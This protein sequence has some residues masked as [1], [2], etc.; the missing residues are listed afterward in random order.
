[1]ENLQYSKVTNWGGVIQDAIP[2]NIPLGMFSDALNFELTRQGGLHPRLGF[3]KYATTPTPDGRS[4]RQIFWADLDG[5][6][7]LLVSTDQHVYEFIRASDTWSLI[8]TMTSTSTKRMGFALLNANTA[9]IVIFGNGVD[10]LKQWDGTTVTNCVGAPVGRPVAFKNYIA[11]FDIVGYPGKVQFSINPGDPD[12]WIYGGQ[13]KYLEMRGK[14][15]SIFP[16]GGGLLVY[17]ETRTEFFVGDPDYAQG[18]TSLS[19]TIGCSSHETVADCGGYLTWL[20]QAGVVVW[21]GGAAFPT[22]NLSDP[23]P[24]NGQLFSTIQRDI[25][26]IDW[27][28]RELISAY[29]NSEKKKYYLSAK[30]INYVGSEPFW[31]TLVYDFKYKA[32]F[33]W[34]LE[35]TAAEMIV[36]DRNRQ[37]ALSGTYEGLLRYQTSDTLA[38]EIASG[39]NEYEFWVKSGDQC[40]GTPFQDK[41]FR[42][43]IFSIG[44]VVEDIPPGNRTLKVDIHGEFSRYG[45]NDIDVNQTSGGFTLD[46]SVLGDALTEGYRLAK[47]VTKIALRAKYFNWLVSGSGIKQSVNLVGLNIG[48]RPYS[49]RSTLVK[50]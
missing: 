32:W 21:T 29:Y 2:G 31:R 8:Y 38:D 5:D 42:E 33:P 41:V 28:S 24:I 20:S 40:F 18:M 37:L 17:T 43:L 34:D 4:I 25:D 22:A 3:A 39:S 44:G 10:P 9:P 47:P 15:T 48:Y 13:E 11:V 30:L 50:E 14:V 27:N 23:E 49:R 6:L 19:E 36:D 1:M 16:Y 35:I 45:V 26:R 12:V 7:R 46:I